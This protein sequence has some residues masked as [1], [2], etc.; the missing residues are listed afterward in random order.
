MFLFDAEQSCPWKE[1]LY[2]IEEEMKI[3]TPIKFCLF[4]QARAS[5]SSF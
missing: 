4:E 3:E 5:L 2:E 1:H